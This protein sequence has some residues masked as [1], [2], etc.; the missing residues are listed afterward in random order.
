VL[1]EPR[2]ESRRLSAEVPDVGERPDLHERHG[3]RRPL[4]DEHHRV[5]AQS[6]GERD[7]DLVADGLEQGSALFAAVV[8]V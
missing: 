1:R 5:V 4:A 7:V 3:A 8:E 2:A 6:D